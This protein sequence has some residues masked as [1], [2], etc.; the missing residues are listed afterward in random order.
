MIWSTEDQ[1]N[2]FEKSDK[3][4]LGLIELNRKDFLHVPKYE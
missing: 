2:E 3:T 1:S 4:L